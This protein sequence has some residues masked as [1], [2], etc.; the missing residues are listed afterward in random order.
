MLLTMLKSDQNVY[1]A[2]SNSRLLHA[3]HQMH[4]KEHLLTL[5]NI[6]LQSNPKISQTEAKKMISQVVVFYSLS[7]ITALNS[8]NR[9]FH[10]D[11]FLTQK[12]PLKTG[13]LEVTSAV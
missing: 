13:K 2:G 12:I 8:Y 4:I 1:S 6:I 10:M 7:A 9:S 5:V 11:G 3:I